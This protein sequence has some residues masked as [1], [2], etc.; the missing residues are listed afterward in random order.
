MEG[1]WRDGGAELGGQSQ[2]SPAP[3]LA[4]HTLSISLFSLSV[5][6]SVSI[7]LSLC[8]A[9]CLDPPPSGSI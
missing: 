7:C 9:V 2:M 3:A 6:V 5:S 8:L 1:M 4:S